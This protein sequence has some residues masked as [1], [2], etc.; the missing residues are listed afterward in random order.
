MVELLKSGGHAKGKRVGATGVVFA[1]AGNL[2]THGTQAEG[3][4]CA[5]ITQHAVCF[6]R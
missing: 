3:G 4:G 6:G 2:P 1:D 5:A